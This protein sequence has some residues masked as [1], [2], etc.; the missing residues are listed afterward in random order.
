MPGCGFEGIFGGFRVSSSNGTAKGDALRGIFGGF[1]RALVSAE[2]GVSKA[3]SVFL[4]ALF[5][6]VVFLF[7][8]FARKRDPGFFKA[9]LRLGFGAGNFWRDVFACFSR[10]VLLSF[11]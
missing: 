7:A 8:A 5:L 11:D 9:R 1:R 4:L 6:L 3:R 10:N 2:G